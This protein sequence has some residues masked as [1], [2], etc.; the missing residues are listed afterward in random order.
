MEKAL[1]V[2]RM[3]SLG[4]RKEDLPGI[5]GISAEA[6][7]ELLNLPNLLPEAQEIVKNGEVAAG[8]AIEIIKEEQR[9]KLQPCKGF[10]K[11]TDPRHHSGKYG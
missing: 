4:A 3:L 9:E 10:Q 1:N 7:G 5:L 2:Q 8:V 11:A 6:I